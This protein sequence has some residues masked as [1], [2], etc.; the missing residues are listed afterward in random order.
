[1]TFGYYLQNQNT[2]AS[3]AAPPQPNRGQGAQ[4]LGQ[5]LQALR[6]QA[7]TD[8]AAQAASGNAAD[9]IPAGGGPGGGP[10]PN[11]VGGG[12]GFRGG[13]FRAAT[14]AA[15]LLAGFGAV[16][17]A[18]LTVAR[19]LGR[20]A[21][22]TLAVNQVL[23][24]Y[25][26]LVASANAMAEARGMRRAIE[27]GARIGPAYTRLSEA[28]SDYADMRN[29]IGAP[30]A[31]AGQNALAGI[32]ESVNNILRVWEPYL[33]SLANGVERIVTKIFGPPAAEKNELIAESMLRDFADGKFDGRG[34]SPF[35]R[36]AGTPLGYDSDAQRR[37]LFG[38]KNPLTEN[39][40]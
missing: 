30:L 35:L 24:E 29:R 1:M 27:L 12:G 28:R 31:S 11:Q 2:A 25:N 16:A 7:A 14:G 32:Q 17:G 6:N 34:Q 21:D 23:E 13:V 22:N 8:R 5:V 26:A 37:R 39:W 38:S 3:R 33:I 4:Q 9:T 36:A 15:G 10:A 19:R 18:A 40:P 20:M